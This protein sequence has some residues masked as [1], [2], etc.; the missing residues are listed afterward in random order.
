MWWWEPWPVTTPC[1]PGAA[2]LIWHPQ[3]FQAFPAEAV[4]GPGQ[5]SLVIIAPAVV[6]QGEQNNDPGVKMINQVQS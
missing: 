4:Q 3:S 5:D 6:S 2:Q 1:S